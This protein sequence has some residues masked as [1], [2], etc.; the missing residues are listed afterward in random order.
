MTGNATSVLVTGGAGYVGSH[1]CK[2]LSEA[3]YLPVCYDNLSTGNAWAVKWGPLEIGDV[4]DASRLETVMRWHRPIAVMHFAARSLVGESVEDPGLY[5]RDNVAGTITLLEACRAAEVTAVVFSSSCA[6]YGAPRAVPIPEDAPKAPISP[7]GVAKLMCEEILGEYARAYGFRH[8][9]LRYFNAA[10]ADADGE[11]G[12]RREVETHLLPLALDAIAGRRFPF[13]IMG[14]DYPTADGTAVR[15]FIHVFDLAEAHV[16]ALRYLLAGGESRVLNLGTGRGHSV[17]EVLAAVERVSGRE[18]P[19]LALPRRA[20]DPAELIADP[21]LSRAVL[22]ASLT[23]R[24]QLEYI[25][26][27]AWQWQSGTFYRQLLRQQPAHHKF[28]L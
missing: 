3:G 2:A 12:E 26:K 25:V 27:T 1:A 6:V 13:K 24:S 4:C 17:L 9:A 14:T 28:E 10:G 15:D 5:F 11:I 8:V 20:G 22:G 18:L 7:Y 16:R 23:Q 19:R 21:S